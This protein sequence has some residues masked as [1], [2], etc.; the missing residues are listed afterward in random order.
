M[1]GCRTAA[2]I[3]LSQSACNLLRHG[4]DGAAG[5]SKLSVMK[6]QYKPYIFAE[7]Y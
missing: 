5:F 7:P 3:T 4:A 6:M 2:H 1:S